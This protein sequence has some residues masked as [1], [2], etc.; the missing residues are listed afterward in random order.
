MVL[1]FKAIQITYFEK[2]SKN[3]FWLTQK[4]GKSGERCLQNE[5]IQKW[6]ELTAIF[7]WIQTRMQKFTKILREVFENRLVSREFW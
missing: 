3:T 1:M 2:N 4:S 5:T 6:H 7:L